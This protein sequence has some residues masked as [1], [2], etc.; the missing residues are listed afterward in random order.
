VFHFIPN[1]FEGILFDGATF[2]KG[3]EYYC[4]IGFYHIGMGSP[5]ERSAASVVEHVARTGTE[6]VICYHDDCYTLFSVMAPEF[7][8]KVPF[9]PV[10]WLEF[11]YRQMNDLKDQI[12][13]QYLQ[14][15]LVNYQ[16]IP[17]K[18]KTYCSVKE[19]PG[20]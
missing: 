5:V 9:R 15:V 1:L 8:V 16:R 7:G 3:G 14:V 13:P 10:S 2:L 6:E 19:Q 12:K 18:L 17:R 11:L 20:L 4:G